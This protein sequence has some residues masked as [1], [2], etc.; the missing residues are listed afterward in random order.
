MTNTV[1]SN[2]DEF[3]YQ[4]LQCK[5]VLTEIGHRCGYVKLPKDHF[6]FKMSYDDIAVNIHGGL[7]FGPDK[8]GWIGFDCAHCD[9]NPQ[10]WTLLKTSNEVK[11]LAK[12]INELKIENCIK[13]K[14]EY[15]PEWFTKRVCV[16]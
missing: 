4:G 7:T 16:K 2:E 13:L 10:E 11:N 3:I 9:D 12:Q 15:M 14:L 6:A 1:M 5:V 8:L